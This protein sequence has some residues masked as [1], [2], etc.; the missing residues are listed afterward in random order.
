MLSLFGAERSARAASEASSATSGF[1][2]WRAS[3]RLRKSTGVFRSNGSP[4]SLSL[5]SA[6]SPW[7]AYA[8]TSPELAFH[9]RRPVRR[10]EATHSL[11]VRQEVGDE[12]VC[13]LGL[14]GRDHVRQ[15]RDRLRQ[16][17]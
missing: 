6:P 5:M 15:L 11:G 12:A 17:L 9:R 13:R 10:G 14:V 4:F 1:S 2:A 8:G 3:S 16:A 7:F